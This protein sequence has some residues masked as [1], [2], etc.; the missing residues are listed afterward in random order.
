MAPA[1]GS[2]AVADEL[3]HGDQAF[4]LGRELAALHGVPKI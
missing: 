2:D 3:V 4:V 1:F